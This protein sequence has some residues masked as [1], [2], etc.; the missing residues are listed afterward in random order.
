MSVNSKRQRLIKWVRRYPVIALSALALA[1]LLGGFSEKDDG[2]ISQQLII[3]TLYLFVGVVP[4]GF[5]IAFVVVGR[6][7]DLESAANREKQSNL[8][9]QDWL[10][11]QVVRQGI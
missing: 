11:K 10:K 3:T 2:F 7:G 4:L 6:L 5:I 1:Y 9:Y 8:T